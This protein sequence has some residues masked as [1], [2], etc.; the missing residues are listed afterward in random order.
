VFVPVAEHPATVRALAAAHRELLEVEEAALDA[1]AGCGEPVAS[2]L[3]RLH[4]RVTGLLA[5]D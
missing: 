1:I 4:R 3:V 5:A 2:D